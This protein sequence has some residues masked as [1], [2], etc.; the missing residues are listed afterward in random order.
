[1]YHNGPVMTYQFT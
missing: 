1:M